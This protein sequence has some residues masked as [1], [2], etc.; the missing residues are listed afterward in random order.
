VAPDGATFEDG[1]RANVVSDAIE[2]SWRSG[3]RV[4]VVYDPPPA[5]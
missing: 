1:Y 5:H 4:D 3:R 2:E